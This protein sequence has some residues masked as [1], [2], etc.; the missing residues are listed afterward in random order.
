MHLFTYL[1]SRVLVV[2]LLAELLC[3]LGELVSG[4]SGV[5]AKYFEGRPDVEHNFR[6]RRLGQG[7]V[8]GGDGEEMFV[9]RVQ[10]AATMKTTR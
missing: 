4:E 1:F 5:F 9:E 2:P 8:D 3:L 10:L 6:L 7:S